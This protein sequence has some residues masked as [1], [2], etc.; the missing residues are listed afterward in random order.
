MDLSDEERRYFD[1]HHCV[2]W[3][4]AAAADYLNVS[5]LYFAICVRLYERANSHCMKTLRLI[6]AMRLNTL[7]KEAR[8]GPAKWGLLELARLSCAIKVGAMN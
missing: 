5:R 4:L 8:F 3:E 1:D 6:Q 2:L 7:G